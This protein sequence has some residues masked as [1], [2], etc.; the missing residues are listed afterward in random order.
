MVGK[1]MGTCVCAV[2]RV[3]DG[4]RARVTV[5]VGVNGVGGILCAVAGA[6][7]GVV[8]ARGRVGEWG[9]GWGWKRAMMARATTM[10]RVVEFH[11][12]R[13]KWATLRG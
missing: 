4:D 7:G 12:Y 1:R 10:V 8:R 5:G 9:H 3:N 6:R 11:A 13:K 2:G